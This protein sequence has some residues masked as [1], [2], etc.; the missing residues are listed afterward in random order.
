MK[1]PTCQLNFYRGKGRKQIGKPVHYSSP[2]MASSQKNRTERP[3]KHDQNYNSACDE[4]QAYK[5][6]ITKLRITKARKREKKQTPDDEL[7]SANWM[8][9]KSR[10]SVGPAWSESNQMNKEYRRGSVS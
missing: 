5:N 4:D 2:Q 6:W 10:W 9:G 7:M 1:E 8:L 3:D